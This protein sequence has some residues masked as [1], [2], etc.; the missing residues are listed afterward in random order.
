MLKSPEKS[1]RHR[2]SLKPT[3]DNSNVFSHLS[4]W[5]FTPVFS[6][7]V[8]VPSNSFDV[9]VPEIGWPA[10]SAGSPGGSSA[11]PAAPGAPRRV[12]RTGALW[13]RSLGPSSESG[14]TSAGH[15]RAACPV[16]FGA[17]KGGKTKND[18]RRGIGMWLEGKGHPRKWMESALVS[19]LPCF[20]TTGKSYRWVLA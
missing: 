14:K 3:L 4:K 6:A 20:R 19:G 17:P 7:S 11:S 9:P 16:W 10:S 2:S 12:G 15:R 13:T 18:R 5:K 8:Q 1:S